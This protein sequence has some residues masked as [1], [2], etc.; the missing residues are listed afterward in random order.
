MRAL[1]ISFLYCSFLLAGCVISRP[2]TQVASSILQ[3]LNNNQTEASLALIQRANTRD[4]NSWIHYNPDHSKA[5]TLLVMSIS[6]RP[7]SIKVVESLLKKGVNPDRGT[8]NGVT[9][10]MLAAEFDNQELAE[11]LLRYG[12]SISL[13]F[14]GRNA[15]DWCLN[16]QGGVMAIIRSYQER[17]G[18]NQRQ[19]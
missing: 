8:K 9:P 4:L 15:S 6:D 10:L 1:L 3:C 12:A 17:R 16:R 14:E 5:A 18:G 19:Y 2:D 7:T 13:T 11:I